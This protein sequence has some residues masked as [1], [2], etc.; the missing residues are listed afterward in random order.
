MVKSLNL[1]PA[2][3]TALRHTQRGSGAAD[4]QVIAP[5]MQIAPNPY[6]AAEQALQRAETV[7]HAAVDGD[8]WPIIIGAFRTW[9]ATRARVGRLVNAQ[10]NLLF[11][12]ELDKALARRERQ[13][14]DDGAD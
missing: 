9:Q 13:L 2:K 1:T 12:E 8:D 5:G 6:Q 14:R 7:F 10:N 3:I 11:S 4:V